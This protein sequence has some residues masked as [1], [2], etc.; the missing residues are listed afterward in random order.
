MLSFND[1]V[2]KQRD[3]NQI[4][5]WKD[6][7]AQSPQKREEALDVLDDILYKLDDR[8][9]MSSLQDE[10]LNQARELLYEVYDELRRYEGSNE[11]A[12]LRLQDGSVVDDYNPNHDYWK[13][14]VPYDDAMRM[15]NQ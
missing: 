8:L 1:M 14:D 4:G 12:H 2:K 10:R 11:I 6:W 7:L 5:K 3:K 15:Y 13:G 9:G